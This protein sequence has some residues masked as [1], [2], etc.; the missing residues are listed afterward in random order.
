MLCKKKQPARLYTGAHKKVIPEI[1]IMA[2][3]RRG[4]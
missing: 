1:T 4:W 3:V 2:F